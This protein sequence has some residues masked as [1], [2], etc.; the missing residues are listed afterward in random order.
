MPLDKKY[1]NLFSEISNSKYMDVSVAYKTIRK[2]TDLGTLHFR[3]GYIG[4]LYT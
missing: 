1:V 3:N 2:H 4:Y